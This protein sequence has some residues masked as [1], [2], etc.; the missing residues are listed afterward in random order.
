MTS[1]EVVERALLDRIEELKAELRETKARYAALEIKAR[2]DAKKLADI[3]SIIRNGMPDRC[4]ANDN[5]SDVENG[6]FESP[7]VA[8]EK[9]EVGDALQA[10]RS[11]QSDLSDTL[12]EENKRPMQSAPAPAQTAELAPTPVQES[13][14][15]DDSFQ[16]TESLAS[17]MARMPEGVQLPRIQAGYTIRVTPPFAGSLTARKES[18]WEDE[19]EFED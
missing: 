16:Q 17:V 13:A 7:A 18:V 11:G 8:A 15:P 6:R 19:D 2:D 1:H 9:S 5:P 3:A 10:E 4:G 14:Q 12:Q